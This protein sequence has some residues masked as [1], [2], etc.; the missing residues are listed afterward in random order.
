MRVIFIGD[1][2]GRSLWKEIVEKE[3][4]AEVVVFY[5][6]YFDSKEE[7]GGEAQLQNFLEIIAFK[8]NQEKLGKKVVLLFGNHDYHYMPWYTR[9]P[10]S[11]FTEEFK[12]HFQKA[13]VDHLHHLQ[14]VF[15]F[16]NV[17]CSHAGISSIWVNRN[18]GSED[19]GV[20]SRHDLPGLAHAIN[21]LFLS[22]PKKFDSQGFESS[23]DEPQQTPIWIRPKSLRESN[24]GILEETSVQVVG[25]TRVKDAEA[26][27]QRSINEW[28]GKYF[29]VDSLF[30]GN[31]L[32]WDNGTWQLGGLYFSVF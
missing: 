16:E 24:V 3:K 15:S 31:Y 17:F 21:Q 9:E 27:F 12:E 26:D 14:I 8:T 32:I 13:L 11:G 2:H 7:I 30:L 20:W 1:I 19:K 5:G 6:D 10:Y 28:E 25:H 4:Y 23:G 18:I 29:L 22:D